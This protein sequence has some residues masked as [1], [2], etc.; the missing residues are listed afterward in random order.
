MWL[1]VDSST[2]VKW[3]FP[4][5]LTGQAL[6]LRRA[7]ESSNVELIAPTL[8]LTEVGN[9]VWKKQRNAL[10]T[11][12]EGAQIVSHLL[13]LELPLVKVQNLLPRAYQLAG[14]FQRTVYDALYLALAEQMEAEF[15][16]ADLRLCNAVHP[17]LEFVRY[18]GNYSQQ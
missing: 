9:V 15:V 3:F 14:I 11:Y 17:M 16:T 6:A 1:V 18:L 5:V 12:E 8:L 13:A 2:V 10:V 4:E 7:W